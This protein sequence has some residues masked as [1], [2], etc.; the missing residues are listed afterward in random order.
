MSEAKHIEE[1]YA[2]GIKNG[3]RG[4]L[5]ASSI[6]GG[7]VPIDAM[8]SNADYAKRDDIAILFENNEIG[9]WYD[10]SDI[11]TLFQDV[12][13]TTPV[14]ADG[15]V[16]K[17]IKDKSGN[18][19]HAGYA[20]AN[21]NLVYH[22]SGGL[23]WVENIG[24][25][26]G[27][28]FVKEAVPTGSDI[29]IAAGVELLGNGSSPAICTPAGFAAG[30]SIGFQTTLRKMQIFV[31]GGT[32]GTK[33]L[34]SAT[35]NALNEKVIV[36]EQ[37][38]NEGFLYGRNNGSVPVFDAATAGTIGQPTSYFL[39]GG[40]N[41]NARL[42][43]FVLVASKPSKEA[44]Y[45]AEE[46]MARKAGATINRKYN[47]VAVGDSTIAAYSTYASIM[48]YLCSNYI[49]VTCAVPGHTIAQQKAAWLALATR[50]YAKWVTVEVGLNDLDPSEAAAPA[51]ARLQDLVNTVR[52]NT[53]GD[54]VIFIAK[55]VPCKQRLIDV[56]GAVD[57]LVS[58]AKWLA[59]NEAI[60]G[61]GST[62]I[63]GVSG[64]ITAHEAA[65]NDGS[66]NLAP[67]YDS[68]DHIHETNAGRKI[69]GTEWGNKIKA[70]IGVL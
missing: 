59:I 37:W 4:G 12:L 63:T 27:F 13:G 50:H 43:G 32:A 44:Q 46:T 2:L 7:V 29:F 51:I 31:A 16:V 22:T 56:Y 61:G 14:T 48:E 23:S 21:S 49:K 65:L 69:I 11:T 26:D 53:A 9:V 38:D 57:G 34:T 62:P 66:G 19:Y 60:T 52:A 70:T 41:T 58:Y 35:A 68:G 1:H 42:Y 10:P 45:L 36:S 5:S 15:Q 24:S 55:M 25:T 33:L 67:A 40:Q 3:A 6:T 64:R 30:I 54:P 28:S 8:P 17:L 20:G 18:G 47:C 39:L